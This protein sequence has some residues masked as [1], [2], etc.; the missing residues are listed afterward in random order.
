[1]PFRP[2]NP[3][4]PLE[5]SAREWNLVRER[6]FS[7][8]GHA[9]AAPAPDTTP[10]L[11]RFL[12]QTGGDLPRGGVVAL[13]GP[14]HDPSADPVQLAAWDRD[15]LLVGVV[16][17]DKLHFW[18]F[19]IVTLPTRA[20][21]VGHCVVSGLVVARV[22]IVRRE[23]WFASP[24]DG[25]T[26]ALVSCRAGSAQIV[27][28][29]NPLA[30]GAQWCL[31]RLSN[32]PGRLFRLR[33]C[34][35]PR[36]VLYTQSNLADFVD[37]IVR[38]R[39]Q[40]GC[41]LVEFPSCWDEQCKDPVC[42]EVVGV[43]DQCADCRDCWRLEDCDN[44][45]TYIYTDEDLSFYDGRVVKL[46][47]QPDKCWEVSREKQNC[48][49][50]QQVQIEDDF[51]Q[52]S[53][54][55]CWKLVNCYDHTQEI[56]TT[57]NLARQL[58]KPADQVIGTPVLL[59]ERPSCWKIAD[60][61]TQYCSAQAEPITI[62][63][64]LEECYCPCVI[65]VRCDDTSVKQLI[66][67]ATNIDG[68]PIDLTKYIGQTVRDSNGFCW[69]LN[70][71]D[72]NQCS[73]YSQGGLVI[74]EAFADCQACQNLVK[75]KKCGT[76]TE[77]VTYSDLTPW[78]Q[79]A[80][81]NVY[82]RDDGTCWEVTQVGGLSWTGNEEDFYAVGTAVGCTSCSQNYKLVA[83]CYT[84]GCQDPAKLPADRVAQDPRLAAATGGYV[85]WDGYC[86]KVSSTTDAA[87]HTLGDFQGP[88]GSC[89][90]CLAG[91]GQTVVKSVV[92]GVCT[93]PNTG[94]NRFLVERWRF[95]NGLLVEVCNDGCLDPPNCTN[96]C[97]TGSGGSGGGGG[98]GGSNNCSCSGMPNQLTLTITTG[99]NAC[100]CW[101]GKTTTLTW[102][103]SKNGWTGLMNDAN[104]GVLEFFLACAA[105]GVH[106]AL[107]YNC[108][109]GG[110]FFDSFDPLALDCAGK[111][112]TYTKTL[113]GGCCDMG[114]GGYV[115]LEVT[116]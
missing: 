88:F 23:H 16:P 37:R 5:I 11:V 38:L 18:R 64:V 74:L 13:Q 113:P 48:T 49:N 29:E 85:R 28:K 98:G 25:M 21:Q 94:K 76:T 89:Q 111:R 4:D 77:I 93:D 15:R 55:F 12:N 3:G 33:S 45:G 102:D 84:S 81:G 116:W 96:E 59:A 61:G 30:T 8:R 22:W 31:V 78:G 50:L 43:H 97:D 67:F 36:Q 53:D 90:D 19:G 73:Q 39:G 7:A 92:V 71:I 68:A 54:C 27:A 105:A 17:Q 14:Y 108:D 52:C 75:L 99:M 109:G 2:A 62:R 91:G 95:E 69:T 24:Y 80:V 41:Y 86:W 101:Q 112:I 1:M 26:S 44:P 51:D 83:D 114:F 72:P 82:L 32:A 70:Q 107:K 60:K 35:D 115:E 34:D 47:G 104:C 58:G 63:G 42:V 110:L 10:D 20:G 87:T 57:S 9:P 66:N 40:Q 100:S 56:W 103:S 46:Q 79:V 65:A 106:P 6:A